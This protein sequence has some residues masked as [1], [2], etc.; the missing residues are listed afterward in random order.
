[1]STDL[2]YR[3][4]SHAALA[5]ACVC[6]L[7]AAGAFL[8]GLRPWLWPLPVLVFVAA[9][10]EG[11]WII[12][13]WLANLLGLLIAGGAGWWLHVQLTSPDGP[14]TLPMPIGLVPHLA[15]V[16]P[17]LLAVKLYR[18]RGPREFWSL[19]GLG[20]LQVGL[21]C[22]LT[23]E[24]TFGALLL[25]YL[26]CLL[27]ALSLRESRAV[28]AAAPSG[29]PRDG[30]WLRPAVR[31]TLLAAAGGLLLFLLTPRGDWSAWDPSSRFSG[32]NRPRTG[33][34]DLVNLNR[35]GTIEVD[36]EEAF[37]VVA[38]DAQGAPKVDLPPDQLWRGLVL[39]RYAR[40]RWVRANHIA[41]RRLRPPER[42]PDLG[43]GQF[44]LDVTVKPARAGG[45][46]LA[47]PIVLGGNGATLPVVSLDARP[48]V[49]FVEHTGST[50]SS[51][52]DRHEYHYRQVV[53]S[54]PDPDL[55]PATNI[56]V[57]YA[58]L[59]I[60]PPDDRRSAQLLQQWADDLMTRLA[61]DPRYGL[62]AEDAAPVVLD[63]DT[64]QVPAGAARIARALTRYLATSG[65]YTYTLDQQREDPSLDPAVDFLLN[66]RQGH[67]ERYATGLAVLLRA[68]GVPCRLVKGYRGAEHQG[69][70]RYVVRKSSSH[71]WIE[72]LV[73]ARD[74]RGPPDQP[75]YDWLELDPTPETEEAP[76]REDQSL[77]GWWQ[78]EALWRDL[79]VGYG[80][81]KQTE[82]WERA[83]S[84]LGSL[85]RRAAAL[86][87]TT[88]ALALA[89]GTCVVLRRR[90]SVL[91]A[92]GGL[93]LYARLV[94]LLRRHGC[95]PPAP[96]QTPREHAAAA[97]A[98][99]AKA[100][101]TAALAGLPA[102]LTESHYR[103]RFGG[104]GP[105]PEEV[106]ELTAGL[107]ALRAG[108]ASTALPALN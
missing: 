25:A 94:A 37:R 5:L 65:D 108:L 78:A 85:L 69:D 51:V 56:D 41:P 97:G 64:P 16:L 29:A 70:G 24:P 47:E 1:V 86:L 73:P 39:E 7:H 89:V 53:P 63:R 38:T 11:R 77:W 106:A 72:A 26:G 74:R 10:G 100:A 91:P 15:P 33:F 3:L 60:T 12:P 92:A 21:A 54:K 81:D 6:L 102:R 79:V 93:A 44:F 99:L 46:F 13:A 87:L 76:T 68:R 4:A 35:T 66:V 62:Q 27:T 34:D 71:T 90:R 57:A 23:L 80:A 107:D 49:P 88:G 83:R 98:W 75:N 96:G 82:L 95:P 58:R 101:A 19:H 36:A 52:G 105:T 42:L 20:L 32:D 59:L 45:A 18:P 67:C 14:M 17:A 28:E 50:Q 103:A 61:R 104:Q 8:G 2:R 84:S 22:A 9:F 30:R 55:S 31:V 40:G 43:P 48:N